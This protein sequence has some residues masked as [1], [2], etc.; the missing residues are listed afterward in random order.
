MNTPA[1]SYLRIRQYILSLV[2][3]CN[4]TLTKIPPEREICKL[5]SVS[6]GSVRYALD[7]LVDEGYL[8]RHHGAG[9]FINPDKAVRP[10]LKEKTI[11]FIYGAGMNVNYMDSTL[12]AL[13][14]LCLALAEKRLNLRFIQLLDFQD[15]PS[16]EISLFKL[17]ALL[18][19]DPNSSSN[20][21]AVIELFEN[22]DIPFLV[23]ADN[24]I[25]GYRNYLTNDYSYT[26]EKAV[27][28][29]LERGH[30]DIAFVAYDE[31]YPSV[32]SQ[33]KAFKA[34]L[35]KHGCFD[36]TLRVDMCDNID[37][38]VK[39]FLSKRKPS[40]I[41]SLG[42]QSQ[43]AVFKAVSELGLN[44]DEYEIISYS[45]RIAESF[46][47]VDFYEIVAER[48]GLVKPAVDLLCDMMDGKTEGPVQ[49]VR[50]FDFNLN[51]AKKAI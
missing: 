17:D 23:V 45:S 8:L 25:D 27:E 39:D 28:Y 38:K 7:T 22:L 6:R 29:L 13:G 2:Y 20:G 3:S 44:N 5:F 35:E 50:K 32:V 21:K 4:G 46:E 12:K 34:A 47:N 24:I 48:S 16:S 37:S 9:T 42:G 36:K 40:A 19:L 51:K 10:E 41:Y 26:A 1:P 49:I 15:K 11:G 18:W 14:N 30:R 31:K 33:Y 43:Y